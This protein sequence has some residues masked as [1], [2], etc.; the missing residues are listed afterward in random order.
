MTPPL[1]QIAASS[2]SQ[3]NQTPTDPAIV[4]S[5]SVPQPRAKRCYSYAGE[6]VRTCNIHEGECGFY[7]IENCPEY[8]K[9]NGL[10]PLDIKC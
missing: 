10:P 3:V 5:I 2:S 9:L 7:H 6:G 8:R 1:T 4:L